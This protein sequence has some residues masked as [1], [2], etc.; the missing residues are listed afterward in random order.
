MAVSHA[1]HPTLSALMLLLFLQPG[2]PSFWP[3][4][5]G[6]D[7]ALCALVPTPHRTHQFQKN[8]S[9]NEQDLTSDPV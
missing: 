3:P 5:S 8:M 6:L 4:L 2:A 7:T 1:P 9:Q